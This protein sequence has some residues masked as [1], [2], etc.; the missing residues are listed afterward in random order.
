MLS[1]P[2]FRFLGERLDLRVHL[3]QRSCRTTL[4]LAQLAVQTLLPL[5]LSTQ[6]APLKKNPK[7]KTRM[8]VLQD[9]AEIADSSHLVVQNHIISVLFCF[10]ILSIIKHPE[11]ELGLD[12]LLVTHFLEKSPFPLCSNNRSPSYP[13]SIRSHPLP[14]R[15]MRRLQ[16][17]RRKRKTE[18]TSSKRL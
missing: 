4:H 11:K 9:V 17:I 3:T 1:F 6:L 13:S 15:L 10:C 16:T 8:L 12:Q 7:Q 14:Y 18:D 5:P 2:L